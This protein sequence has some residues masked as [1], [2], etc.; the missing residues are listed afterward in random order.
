MSPVEGP[1]PAGSKEPLQPA[2]P[3]IGARLSH[4]RVLDKLGDGRL[5]VVYRAEDTQ[6]GREVAIRVLRQ[7][8]VSSLD[9][10]TRLGHQAKILAS[11]NHRNIATLHQVGES[12][13][14][15]FLVMELVEGETLAERIARGPLGVEKA[16]G[17]A[18]KIAEALEAAHDR[19]IVHRDLKPANVKLTPDGEVKVLDFGMAKAMESD[20]RI[21]LHQLAD[22]ER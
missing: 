1:G 22:R 11:L 7:E 5:G 15:R 17:I 19:G 2:P 3:G 12:N 4:F 16:T 21:G 18:I 13:G 6:L 14:R 20:R 10:L 9:R 8:L